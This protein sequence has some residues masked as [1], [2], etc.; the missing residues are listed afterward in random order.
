MQ[1]SAY[2]R[3]ARH[4]VQQ[5]GF[6]TAVPFMLGPKHP[7]TAGVSHCLDLREFWRRIMIIVK[8]N[9]FTMHF[10]VCSLSTLLGT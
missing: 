4:L 1:M 10:N 2:R 9:V 8:M 6:P 7:R 5:P 3:H